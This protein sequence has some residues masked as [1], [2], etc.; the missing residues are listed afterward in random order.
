MSMFSIADLCLLGRS[1]EG[2]LDS[3]CVVLKPRKAMMVTHDGDF[4]FKPEFNLHVAGE[5]RGC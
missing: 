3:A 5:S 4:E 1:G 2:T